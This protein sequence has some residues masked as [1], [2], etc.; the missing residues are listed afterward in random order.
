VEIQQETPSDRQDGPCGAAAASTGNHWN[1]VPRSQFHD[2]R[3]LF[4]RSRKNDG[5][6]NPLVDREIPG[7]AEAL[8]MVGKNVFRAYN[9]GD[10]INDAHGLTSKEECVKRR[11]SGF[12]EVATI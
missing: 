11:I 3:H 2:G 7:I 6:R 8:D 5:I 12:F 10:F 4:R 9:L 1:L